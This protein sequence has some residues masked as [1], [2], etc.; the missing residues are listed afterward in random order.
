ME[1][2][3][4]D[5]DLLTMLFLDSSRSNVQL[6]KQLK[7]SKETVS[8][9]IDALI[10]EGY[11]TNFS[12]KIDYSK[13]GF[14]EVT[15]FLRLRDPSDKIILENI[16]YFENHPN[17]TWIGRAFGA[18]DIKVALYIRSLSEISDMISKISRD[19]LESILKID[20][21]I[22]VEKFKAPSSVF[23]NQI[24]GVNKSFKNVRKKSEILG[25]DDM[26]RKIVYYLGQGNRM[27]FIE[28]A[29]KADISVDIVRYRYNKLL[30][31]GFIQG[32]SIILNG[33]RFDKIWC[34]VLINI[35]SNQINKFKDYLKSQPFLSN[36]ME[37]IGI[38][39]FNFTFFASSV[40]EL[41][42][43]LNQ[44][45]TKFSSEIKELEFLFFFKVYKYPKVPECI[46]EKSL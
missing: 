16:K 8:S 38:W 23:L 32:H 10:R 6:S 24:L 34:L 26:D 14:R 4:K 25:V 40:E 3:K 17:S 44:V 28:A 1:L 43:N 2:K 9:R 31:N 41:Y 39:N 18:Y 11:F 20:Y 13:L 19:L 15:L 37:T 42:K 7:I 30:N 5:L 33:N 46:L 21:V 29:N 12:L 45:R 36:Y 27:K 22:V 35:S